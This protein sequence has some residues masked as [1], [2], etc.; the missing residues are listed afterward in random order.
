MPPQ[1]DLRISDETVLIR[2]LL[3]KWST[4]KNGRERPTSD[5]FLDSNFEN[6][7]FIEAEITMNEIHDLF[8]GMKVA[9]LSC[10]LVRGVGF[11]IERRPEEAPEGCSRPEAHVVVGPPAPIDRGAYERAA[12]TIVRDNSVVIVNPPLAPQGM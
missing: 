5:S 4:I 10:L 9:R 11:G 3:P 6:S 8:P 2:I 12:R 1:D 7:C